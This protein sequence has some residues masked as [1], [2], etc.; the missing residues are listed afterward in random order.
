MT[1]LWCK[2]VTDGRGVTEGAKVVGGGGICDQV[3]VQMATDGRG[4]TEMQYRWV[5]DGFVTT[6]S[7]K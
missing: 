2:M 4:V 3:I 6:G 5:S 1:N 7:H